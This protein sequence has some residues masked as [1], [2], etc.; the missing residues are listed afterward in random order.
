VPASYRAIAAR[1]GVSV[2][3]V[4]RALSNSAPVS[5]AL[6]RRVLE[7]AERLRREDSASNSIST[8]RIGLVYPGDPINAEYGGFDAAIMSGVNR[9]AFERRFDVA[10][11]NVVEDKL[12]SESY[13]EFFARKG[14][15]AIVMRSFT[16]RRHICERI[17]DEDFPCVVVADRFD[18]PAV[19]YIC[20]DSR[21]TSQQAVEHLVHLGHRRIAMC[22]HAVRD[23]DH[24][25]R[26]LA[27]CSALE[28]HGIPHRDEYVFEVIADV[29]GGSSAISRL[30]SLPEPPTAIVF[31]DPLATLGGL[32]RAHELGISI[33]GELSVIGFDDSQM[34]RVLYPVYTSVCQDAEDLAYTATRWLIEELNEPSGRRLRDA[35]NAYFEVNSTTSIAPAV[36]VRVSPDGRRIERQEAAS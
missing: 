34:R 3:T 28:A 26:R 25:D 14:V 22:V 19:N 12:E 31:T 20:Y 29:E 33:P 8:N 32:R 5:D 2:A 6:R 1:A 35:R 11:I 9:G 21:R 16:G 30:M 4:S 7:E 13:T 36:S 10:T 15:D 18:H 17:A 24:M 23:S 27:Y